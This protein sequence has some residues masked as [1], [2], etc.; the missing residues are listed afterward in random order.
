METGD[1][2]TL[3]ELLKATL[4]PLTYDRISSGELA[5]I[6]HGLEIK[7]TVSIQWLSENLS[8]PDNF[9]HIALVS[10]KNWAPSTFD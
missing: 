10:R 3:E 8:H 9:L 1:A 6:I 5:V 7:F 4:P 2:V